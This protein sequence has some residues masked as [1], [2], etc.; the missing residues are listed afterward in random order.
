MSGIEEV[1]SESCAIEISIE[2][3]KSESYDLA[4]AVNSIADTVF[5]AFTSIIDWICPVNP[6]TNSREF[7]YIPKWGENMMGNLMYPVMCYQQGGEMSHLFSRN[8]Q[9]IASNLAKHSKRELDYEVK[10][11]HNNVIN[12][13]CLPGGKIAIYHHLLEK[14]DFYIHNMERLG[15]TGYTH[16]E[17]G[18]FVSY[19]GLTTNDVIAAL[20]G[21][22][23][24]HADARHAA[25]KLELSWV[26]QLLAFGIDSYASYS[27]ETWERDIDVKAKNGSVGP[28]QLKK[29]QEDLE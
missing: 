19:K 20:L 3:P 1:S 7:W 21:H 13:W 2:P 29:E 8:V 4:Q 25:R 5:G 26:V 27:L 16:P 6:V 9:E 14:I 15:V 22:E 10:I 28:V 18:A 17:T 12:A 11:L 23:M 24:T